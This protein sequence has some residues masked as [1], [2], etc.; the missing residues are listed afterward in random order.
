MSERK[1]TIRAV[2][3]EDLEAFLE[4]LGLLY[5]MEQEMLRCGFCGEVVRRDNLLSVYPENDEIRV[6]CTSPQCYGTLV[7]RRRGGNAV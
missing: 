3:D 5:P 4:S 6:C 1:H 7:K 2:M